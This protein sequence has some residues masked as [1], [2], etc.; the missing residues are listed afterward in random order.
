MSS[1]VVEQFVQLFEQNCA[2]AS[3]LSLVLFEYVVTFPEEVNTV[4][5]RKFTW[6]SILLLSMRWIMVLSQV[7]AWFPMSEKTCNPYSVVLAVLNNI[8]Y[9]Q[10]ALFTAHRISSIWSQTCHCKP[11]FFVVLILGCVPIA[12]NIVLYFN[13]TV[14]YTGAP[15]FICT[16][17]NNLSG[18]VGLA[19]TAA[20]LRPL[21]V[22]IADYAIVLIFTVARTF[23]MLR[24]QRYANI[25]RPSL[26]QCL[27]RDGTLYLLAML[28]L[29]IAQ[30]ATSATP[31]DIVLIFL[32][33]MPLLLAS[34]FT[35]NLRMVGADRD[36][37]ALDMGGVSGLSTSARTPS[38][39][40]F[41][42][43]AQPLRHN[44]MESFLWEDDNAEVEI[45]G[46]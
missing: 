7:A 42:D 43:L 26:T 41:R 19:G 8:A 39:L 30:M 6:T 12:S 25:A 44:Q 40:I 15:F 17:F 22:K 31:G 5:R 34:R 11:L 46:E 13:W 38:T 14:I 21:S 32:Q 20:V 16:T 33:P 3:T 37:T 28:S 27:V 18:G 10:V 29:N 23:H 24:H 36:P 4:W 45:R 1:A 9:A 2:G 35:L